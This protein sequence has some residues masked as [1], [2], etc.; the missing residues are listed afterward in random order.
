MKQT[1]LVKYNEI[2]LGIHRADIL[3][4]LARKYLDFERIV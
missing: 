3:I 1:S 4:T 2:M